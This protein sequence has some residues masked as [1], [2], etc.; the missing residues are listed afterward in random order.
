MDIVCPRINEAFWNLRTLFYK[1]KGGLVLGRDLNS[2]KSI[3]VKI[4]YAT[5]DLFIWALKLYADVLMPQQTALLGDVVRREAEGPE[6]AIMTSLLFKLLV[7]PVLT[8][9]T[10]HGC[11]LMPPSSNSFLG[12]IILWLLLIDSSSNSLLNTRCIF[13]II[14]VT[15]TVLH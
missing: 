7:A 15:D 5:S 12:S 11:N 1:R 13:N 2:Y 4:M 10:S 8:R 3:G 6:L 9:L 14:T